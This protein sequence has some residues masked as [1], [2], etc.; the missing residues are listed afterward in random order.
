MASF[1]LGRGR[2]RMFNIEILK[3]AECVGE[4]GFPRLPKTVVL[5]EP[6]RVLSFDQIHKPHDLETWIQFHVHDDRY[7]RL[8][9]KPEKYL[10][11]L[12]EMGGVFGIDHSVYRSL[13]RAERI[14]SVYENRV[15]DF[16][17]AENGIRCIP[18]VS[19]G[20][21]D[22]FSYCC[23]GIARGSSI[24]VSTYGWARQKGDKGLFLE[25]FYFVLERIAP[26]SVFFHGK[27]YPE[28]MNRAQK[29]GIPFFHVPGRLEQVFSAR[30]KEVCHG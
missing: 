3:N 13:P 21:S 1:N 29:S 6:Q 9:S 18:N 5:E 26:A 12:H 7:P 10:S 8:Y 24:S 11:L 17:F 4:F 2:Y 27:V 22:S 16:W 20:E 19:W 28:A 15:T 14:Y 30:Q 23:D 25:G